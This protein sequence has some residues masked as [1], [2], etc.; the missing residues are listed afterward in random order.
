[1]NKYSIVEA[2][3][4]AVLAQGNFVG[5]TIKPGPELPLNPDQSI[6]ISRYGG[7]GID[8]DGAL[9]GKSWQFRV[10]GKQDDYESAEVVADAIDIAALSHFSSQVGGV[11]VTEISRVG[12]APTA[13]MTDEAQRTHFICSY[14]I[15]TELALTN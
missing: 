10:I 8:A 6:V 2:W 7:P 9:D 1:M 13:L 3:T 11:W 5:W 12:G 4:E 14:I 15:T